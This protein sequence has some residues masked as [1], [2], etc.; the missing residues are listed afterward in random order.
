MNGG[1]AR[2]EVLWFGVSC[3]DEAL[4]DLLPSDCLT[5]PGEDCGEGL[6]G[7]FEA[8]LISRGEVGRDDI[9]N[10]GQFGG[11]NEGNGV[12]INSPRCR[13]KL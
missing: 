4:Y 8:G 2:R 6:E 12:Y 1:A 13:F 9:V 3:V 7:P 10:R 11:R 5:R